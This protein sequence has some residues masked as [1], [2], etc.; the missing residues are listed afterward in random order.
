MQTAAEGVGVGHQ[1]GGEEG[2]LLF[3]TCLTQGGHLVLEGLGGGGGG[4]REVN[5]SISPHPPRIFITNTATKTNLKACKVSEEN[6]H[7]TNEV[8]TECRNRDYHYRD[9]K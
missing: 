9:Y 3:G 4:V 8:F 5:T 6:L 1:V 2:G 7:P